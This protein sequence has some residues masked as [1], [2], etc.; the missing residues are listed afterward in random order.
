MRN[1]PAVN[2]RDTGIPAREVYTDRCEE[3]KY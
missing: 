2:D 3:I 1:D